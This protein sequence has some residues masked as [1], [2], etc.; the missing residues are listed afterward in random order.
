MTYLKF[1][2]AIVFTFAFTMISYG[3]SSA[4]STL[5]NKQLVEKIF[6]ELMNKKDLTTFDRYVAKDVIDH[7]AWPGQA[8]GVEGLRNAVKG[9]FDGYPD[10][11]VDIQEMIAD[12]IS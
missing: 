2:S 8:P 1:L 7:S 12:V 10:I 9:L 6:E 5:T 4:K 3:Q 11:H